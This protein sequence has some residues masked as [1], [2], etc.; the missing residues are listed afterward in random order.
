[1]SV[2]K[3]FAVL[4]FLDHHQYC[5]RIR[6]LTEGTSFIQFVAENQQLDYNK[7]LNWIEQVVRQLQ[8]YYRSADEKA[9]GMI[10][11]YSIIISKEEE[12]LL[13]DPEDVS[14]HNV[15]EKLNSRKLRELFIHKERAML[16]QK[17][18]I[19]DLF[20]LGKTIRFMLDKCEA[21]EKMQKK[22]K[23]IFERVVYL[24]TLESDDVDGL[25][26]QILTV[27]QKNKRVQRKEIPFPKVILLIIFAIISIL[28]VVI[29]LR[30][31]RKS[32]PVKKEHKSV[33]QKMES[34]PYLELALLYLYEL[35][36][37]EKGL[38]YLKQSSKE[39][40][41]GKSYYELYRMLDSDAKSEQLET[42]IEDPVFE[43]KQEWLYQMPVFLGYTRIDTKKSWEMLLE[44]GE[45]ILDQNPE[46]EIGIR[47]YMATA[48]E[49]LEHWDKALEEYEKL[50]KLV[51]KSTAV[52]LYE[53]MIQICVQQEKEE[54]KWKLLEE[55]VEENPK[56]LKSWRI[57]ILNYC[58]DPFVERNI[59][60]EK[61]QKAI[62]QVPELVKEEE[63]QKIQREFNIMIEG[64]KVWIER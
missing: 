59:C 19:D 2:E 12:I 31:N 4:R 52:D 37:E 7:F 49:N 8:L 1:M 23:R 22:Q 48:N 21:K 40:K 43:S 39:S 9:Y 46:K 62:S 30:T 57:Y 33:E 26:E 61:I 36:Q 45:L 58:K 44:K 3:E 14:N 35:E 15:I 6:D 64:D 42:L 5:D 41:L 11:P 50:T 32:E 34:D 60:E 63:F 55:M 10:S 17:E 47:K 29:G 28:V 20:A 13:L 27:F 53:R 25:I 54:E 56:D 18:K 51:E 16:I 24:T 38:Q